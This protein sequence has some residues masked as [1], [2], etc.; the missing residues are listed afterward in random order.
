LNQIEEGYLNQTLM[1]FGDAK[2][3]VTDLVK[4]LARSSVRPPDAAPPGRSAGRPGSKPREAV[5]EGVERLSLE[6][7]IG[8]SGSWS[9]SFSP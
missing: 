5:A 7:A 3:F 2:A 4:A 9:S 6:V 8:G 1:R